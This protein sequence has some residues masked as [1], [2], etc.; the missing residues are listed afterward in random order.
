MQGA[1]VPPLARELDPAGCNQDPEQTKKYINIFL[2]ITNS[3]TQATKSKGISNKC[4]WQNLVT[5]ICKELLR[6][7][8]S[9]QTRKKYGHSSV[10]KTVVACKQKKNI[11]NLL[12]NH[13]NAN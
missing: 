11:F 2:K 4:N 1:Q 13:K 3:E 9:Y 12:N 8:N 6:I 7:S 10:Q 5:R